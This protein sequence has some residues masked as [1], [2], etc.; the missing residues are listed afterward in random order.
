MKNYKPKAKEFVQKN[1]DELAVISVM[2][3][4]RGGQKNSNRGR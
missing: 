2:H 1:I 4:L 3:K